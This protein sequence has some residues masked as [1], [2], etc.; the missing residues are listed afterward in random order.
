M[1]HTTPDEI[2]SYWVEE[3]GPEGWYKA[4]AEVDA[5]IRVR[6]EGAWRIAAGGEIRDWLCSPR[7]S[8][9]YLI[10]TD[11][12]P[13]NM[14][15]GEAAAFSTDQI[16]RRAA[17]RAIAQGWDLRIDPPARQFF[18]LPLVH[19]EVLPDQE[20]GVRL[21]LMRMPEGAP[22]LLHARA[23]RAVI[24]RFGRFPH[25]NA[26]LGRRS[27]AA[28]NAFLEAGGYGAVVRALQAEVA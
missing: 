26:A 3:I 19:S 12:F 25:R 22:N 20:Q 28:E 11:Q 1:S 10:L 13:R 8:L 16:A 24:R 18:Y 5:T 7:S 15:R 27:S 21:I 6:F 17:L 9:A 23:H 2:L 14:F 4:D